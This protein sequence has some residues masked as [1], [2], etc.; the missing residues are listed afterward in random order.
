MHSQTIRYKGCRKVNMFQCLKRQEA[1][2]KQWG[3]RLSLRLLQK[4]L[5]GIRQMHD[6]DPHITSST[7]TS[8]TLGL[9]TTPC[10]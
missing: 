10:I 8:G 3:F 6:L 4:P 7:K 1:K 5:Q 2:L 9:P